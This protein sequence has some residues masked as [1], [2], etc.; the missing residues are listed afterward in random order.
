MVKI[1]SH[2]I[3][4]LHGIPKPVR[5][6][7]TSQYTALPFDFLTKYDCGEGQD[8]LDNHDKELD[9]DMAR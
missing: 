7:E 8:S 3:G 1:A 2:A 5:T 6:K 4:P 9:Q